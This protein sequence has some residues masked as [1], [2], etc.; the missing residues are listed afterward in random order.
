MV[1]YC[2]NRRML[3]ILMTLVSMDLHAGE[4]V[5]NGVKI[6]YNEQGK[7]EPVLLIHGLM[8][9]GALNWTVPGITAAL[10][11]DHRVVVM[12]VRG[13]GQ[14]DKPNA[15]DAY[16]VKMV[17]DVI[18]LM[19]HL[20]LPKVHLVGYSMGGMIAMKTAALHPTRVQSLLLCGMGWLEEGSLLQRFWRRSQQP[21]QSS[22]AD[23]ALTAAQVKSLRM[24]AAI[25]IGERDPVE[26]LYVNPLK[27]IRPDWPVTK[28][29]DG[30]H[31]SCVG[32]PAFREAV[33]KF[34][35]QQP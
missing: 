25:I 5:S 8:S 15:A 29:P 23:L 6:A 3:I 24:P 33:V 10:A 34:I 18:A 32:K 16:G 12:D 9:S 31:I 28:I 17:G 35:R 2:M 14:S 4:F 19:D 21:C 20:K 30:G 7:G 1:G 11:R 13:H 26:G 27:K 22:F